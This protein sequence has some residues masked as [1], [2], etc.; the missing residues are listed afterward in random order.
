MRKAEIE[1]NRP[2]PWPLDAHTLILLLLLVLFDWFKK[3]YQQISETR[4]NGQCQGKYNNLYFLWLYLFIY[5][6]FI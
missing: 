3:R 6:T 5:L 4:N 1:S 2:D